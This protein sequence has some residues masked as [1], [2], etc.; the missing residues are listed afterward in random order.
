MN[1]KQLCVP[2][3]RGCDLEGYLEM[4]NGL[5]YF[6][7]GVIYTAKGSVT[8]ASQRFLA[9]VREETNSTR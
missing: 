9:L 5:L 3:E 2:S 4:V 8:L 6:T 1:P 7:F